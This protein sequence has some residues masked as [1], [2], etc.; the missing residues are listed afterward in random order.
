MKITFYV[1]L[2]STL[3]KEELP[4]L[5]Q[6]HHLPASK[7]VILPAFYATFVYSAIIIPKIPKQEV[8]ISFSF[9]PPLLLCFG[10]RNTL[11]ELNCPEVR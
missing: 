1:E 10:V 3:T 2:C 7:A 4:E 9:P 6:P 5:S 11:E 8:A